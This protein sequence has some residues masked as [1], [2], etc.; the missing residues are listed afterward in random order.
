MSTSLVRFRTI[1]LLADTVALVCWCCLLYGIILK[2][3]VWAVPALVFLILM[4]LI[5]IYFDITKLLAS[6]RA[7]C[8]LP[9][10]HRTTGLG[11]PTQFR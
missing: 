8:G 10:V 9:Y 2:A 3:I 4:Y 1:I 11:K 6:R 7:C 5:F